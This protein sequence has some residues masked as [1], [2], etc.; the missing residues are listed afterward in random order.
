MK[1]PTFV[2]VVL[3]VAGLAS[4][5]AKTLRQV[6]EFLS[7]RFSAYEII[8][9]IDVTAEKFR[10]SIQSAIAQAHGAVVVLE[11]AYSQG[12]E[13]AMLAGLDRAMGD[14]V[15]EIDDAR[16]DYPIEILGSMY[17]VARSGNDIVAA[18]PKNLPVSTRFFYWLC[19]KIS[20]IAPPLCYERVRV[21]SRRAVD[22]LLRQ[23]E[24]VR[25]RQVLYRYTGYKYGQV[26]Y[27]SDDKSILRPSGRLAFGI[28]IF[29]SFN[30]DVGARLARVLGVAFIAVSAVALVI[31][32]ARTVADPWW[33][34]LAVAGLFGFAGIFVLFTVT[35]EFLSLILG[36]V[37]NRPP[38]TLDRT[39]TRTILRSSPLSEPDATG[40]PI[41]LG[42]RHH[43]LQIAESAQSADREVRDPGT[44][45]GL[46]GSE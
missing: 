2:S 45:H 19:N 35:C 36:E 41:A 15:F 32:L 40:Q 23:P 22:A 18:V 5:P 17:D 8:L 33:V 21:S 3:R 6:D 44:S 27:R 16:C 24:R 9:V 42:E 43:A 20:S 26:E 13:T 46:R 25:H 10:D 14:F 30:D 38:Y 31:T 11:M 12:T 34:L 37:R 39:L 4:E 7:G 29:W 28:D 1:D